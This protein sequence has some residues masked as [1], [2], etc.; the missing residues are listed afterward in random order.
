MERDNITEE[1]FILREK[2]TIEYQSDDFDYIIKS[3]NI[4]KV[5]KMVNI[6]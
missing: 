2:A 6:L 5:R 3:E 4:E 1:D